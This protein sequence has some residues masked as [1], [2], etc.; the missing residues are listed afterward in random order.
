MP[1]PRYSSIGILGFLLVALGASLIVIPR[2][3]TPLIPAPVS[4][5]TKQ[6]LSEVR[7]RV[8]PQLEA[9]ARSA[10]SWVGAPVLIRGFKESRELEVWMES[11]QGGR[12]ILFRTYA[13]VTWGT[14]TLGPK[15]REGD[16][17]SPEGF[18]EVAV[19]QLNPNSRHHL[20]VN[21]GF[22]NAF[23]RA[24]GRTGSFIM[25]HGGESSI[26]CLAVKDEK[27]EEIY[28][29]AEAALQH[30]Q[31]HVPVHLFP[32]RPIPA[33][34]TAAAGSEWHDFWSNLKEGYD[35][36]ETTRRPPA[37]RVAEGRYHV[38]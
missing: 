27:I 21:I 35:R 4:V 33:R 2:M 31:A 14:G 25:V 12:F 10:G 28:L 11:A 34:L 9:D 18:Y 24:L 37:V 29:L 22:P 3:T 36:F 23:D 15:L 13:I 6:R 16:G 30:G 20:A 7:G 1:L 38:E 26:G 17:Q 8:L 19:S 32:F 5:P